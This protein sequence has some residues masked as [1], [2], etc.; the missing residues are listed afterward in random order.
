[1]VRQLR[2]IAQ[3]L[4]Q[5]GGASA[6]TGAGAAAQAILRDGGV[7]VWDA[8]QGG[9]KAVDSFAPLPLK[10][11]VGI[12]DQRGRLWENTVRF[13]SG[14]AANSVLLWGA[15]GCGKS[16]LVKAVFAAAAK[17]HKALRLIEIARD[18]LDTL[19]DL[20]AFLRAAKGRFI[21]F[22]D[23]LSFAAQEGLGKA[24]K[25]I[26]DGGVDATPEHVVFYATSNRRHLVPRD[27]LE[28]EARAA[29]HSRE[30]QDEHIALSD[31]FGLWIGFHPA[32]QDDYL[33]MVRGYADY[34]GVE[35]GEKLDR[36]ALEWAAARGG[37][38]GRVAWQFMQSVR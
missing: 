23:D 17:E 36:A 27:M 21:V 6:E 24:L 11:L 22:C 7:Y 29:I 19:P 25:S 8:V 2:R 28:N 1:M 33:A 18:D 26:L 37:I 12:E 4:E 16:A 13:A 32:T 3:A 34:F 15:R 20:V 14:K 9:L 38:S 35:K 5:H 31:R 30:A 10:Q